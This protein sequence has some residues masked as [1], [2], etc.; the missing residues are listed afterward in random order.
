[1]VVSM[2]NPPVIKPKKYNVGGP[3][4]SAVSPPLGIAFGN[5]FIDPI[6]APNRPDSIQKDLNSLTNDLK[7]ITAK[8]KKVRKTEPQINEKKEYDD[9]EEFRIW[10]K[11][12]T[13]TDE[14]TGEIFFIQPRTKEK[15]PID[16]SPEGNVLLY[17]V[18]KEQTGRVGEAWDAIADLDI[19]QFQESP[20]GVARTSPQGES[21]SD[22]GKVAE[23]ENSGE[24]RER[25]DSLRNS[26]LKGD[27]GNKQSPIGNPEAMA[28]YAS[29]PFDGSVVGTVARGE[30]MRGL[31]RSE[32]IKEHEASKQFLAYRKPGDKSFS[33]T[34]EPIT[35]Q[36]A[37]ELGY[38]LAPKEMAEE[39]F[40]QKAIL[41]GRVPVNE[42]DP[43][44]EKERLQTDLLREKLR[45]ARASLDEDIETPFMH[46]K[47]VK[48]ELPGLY[49]N[50]GK[51][52]LEFKVRLQ[53]D[54]KGN[55]K[56]DPDVN[57]NPIIRD[58]YKAEEYAERTKEEIDIAK[59]MISG[60]TV[61]SAQLIDRA[62]TG[63]AA[64][65][66]IDRREIYD[67]S[68]NQL[69]PTATLLRRWAKRFT[70]QNITTILGESNRTISDADRK[71][72]D[73]IVSILGT[74]TDISNAMAA[75]N[76][77]VKIFEAPSRNANI[78]LQALYSLAETSP[79]G[80][81]L[82]KVLNM[83]RSVVDQIRKSGM[84][85]VVPQSS[86]FYFQET[87]RPTGITRTIDLTTGG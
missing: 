51:D 56:Y 64:I 54:E 32:A 47:F 14:E 39:N 36:E 76:E 13:G 35:L 48:V 57:L 58:I 67:D 50:S 26:K 80:G 30:A 72:A 15:I 46:K 85:L 28:A 44:N 11:E 37:S 86:Q 59:E 82:D 52:N 25:L 45:K 65:L 8:N 33:L 83:E 24:F 27:F 31:G 10:I 20:D 29:V 49:T 6:V 1:M 61:G 63:I 79:E 18:F 62:T 40:M 41:A 69:I 66:G 17:E 68:G 9:I 12:N 70:A 77:L 23:D 55:V 21:I 87:N 42:D 2:F 38:E 22:V 7:T 19:K 73:D 5:E 75:L 84:P 74:T 78:A 16:S 4:V 34:P 81:Y 71:R 43:M 53:E 3:V 60:Y